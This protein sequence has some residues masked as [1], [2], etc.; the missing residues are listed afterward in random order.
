[1]RRR[2]SAVLLFTVLKIKVNVKSVL[3][4]GSAHNKRGHADLKNVEISHFSDL[5]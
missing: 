3:R 4:I 2:F 1:M 5:F